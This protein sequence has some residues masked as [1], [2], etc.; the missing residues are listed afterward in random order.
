MEKYI[1]GDLFSSDK[2]DKPTDKTIV[3]PQDGSSSGRKERFIG[4]TVCPTFPI[5][6]PKPLCPEGERQGLYSGKRM[7]HNPS[8]CRRLHPE[9]PG[10]CLHSQR[11]TTNSHAGTSYIHCPT[12]H[13]LL[14]SRLFFQMASHT[15]RQRTD[16]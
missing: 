9:T 16:R 12:C 4:R 8:T 3:V 11:R 6:L 15:C 1:Q 14:L 2:A 10:S 5:E 13:G 7:G